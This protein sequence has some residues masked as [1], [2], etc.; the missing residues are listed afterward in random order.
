[1]SF[2]FRFIPFVFLLFASAHAQV[3][4]GLDMDVGLPI[5]LSNRAYKAISEGIADTH[6]KI[7]RVNRKGLGV[8]GGVHYLFN[9]LNPNADPNRGYYLQ[10]DFHTIGPTFGIFYRQD[11]GLKFEAEYGFNTSYL[12]HSLRSNYCAET[13]QWTS[14][15]FNPYFKG[16]FSSSSTRLFF[17]FFVGYNFQNY[18]FTHDF[19]C[20]VGLQG[21]SESDFQGATQYLSFGFGFNYVLKD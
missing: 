9:D 11:G 16:I 20:N 7:Y 4:V 6:L 12:F 1:M 19:L 17:S 3:R 8:A 5:N 2:I 14:L 10:G 18:A 15:G 13:A 21:Y